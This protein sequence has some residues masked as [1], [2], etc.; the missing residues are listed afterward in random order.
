[1]PVP[2]EVVVEDGENKLILREMSYD[3]AEMLE[4]HNRLY[5]CLTE[6]QR[7]V[8]STIMEAISSGSGGIFFL[9]GYWKNILMEDLMFCTERWRHWIVA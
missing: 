9:Y 3:V 6:E 8:Y 7:D 5:P 4:E 2:N 1:M